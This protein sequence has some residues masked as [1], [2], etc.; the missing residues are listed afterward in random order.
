[1]HRKSIQKVV[2][3]IIFVSIVAG[4]IWG[5]DLDKGHVIHASQAG[6]DTRSGVQWLTYTNSDYGFSLDYPSNWTV[7]QGNQHAP[8]LPAETI[9]FQSPSANE[10]S[11]IV[12]HKE[13]TDDGF[14]VAQ[15]LTQAFLGDFIV[16]EISKRE[17]AGYTV[18]KAGYIQP[19]IEGISVQVLLT[20]FAT[21]STSYIVM[22]QFDVG[23]DL[24]T[25][26]SDIGLT[27]K[28]VYDQIVGSFEV[29]PQG[30]TVP[31]LDIPRE[32]EKRPVQLESSNSGLEIAPFWWP[33]DGIIG[34][35]IY[36]TGAGYTSFHKGI[37]IWT[38][39]SGTGSQASNSSKGNAIY[40]VLEGTVRGISFEPW[41]GLAW[42][43]TVAHV[44]DGNNVWTHYNHL[45]DANKL[46]SYVSPSIT[47]GLPV[48][49]QTLLGHQGNR[50]WKNYGSITVHLHLDVTTT[51]SPW[52]HYT[53][54]SPYFLAKLNA[55]TPGHLGFGHGVKH[56]PPCPK[57][58]GT[59]FVVLYKDSDYR[60]GG[61]GEDIGYVKIPVNQ[62]LP[63]TG[64]LPASFGA[65]SIRVPFGYMVKLIEK[66]N[67]VPSPIYTPGT[68][69]R[70]TSIKTFVGEWLPAIVFST[71]TRRVPLDD[72]V[73]FVKVTYVGPLCATIPIA[74]LCP[75]A[76]PFAPPLVSPNILGNNQTVFLGA[77]GASGS[78][79]APS[80]CWDYPGDLEGDEL[81]YLVEVTS[82]L[83]YS[84]SGWIRNTCWR[85][86]QLDHQYGSYHWRVKARDI[87]SA[88]SNW[89]ELGNF[90]ISSP[91][92]PPSVSFNTANSADFTT[93]GINSRTRNWTFAGTASDPEGQLN[94][95]EIRC[96]GDN[97]GNQVSHVNGN[98]WSHSRNN[99]SGQNDIYFIA[100]DNAGNYSFSRHLILRIDL[101]APT[102]QLS[103]NGEAG[104]INWHA[105]FTSPVQ[106]RLN[107]VD[108]A[109]GKAQVG[110]R[111]V[112]YRIDGGIWQTQA[113]ST[114]SFSIS[115][116]G[117]HSIEYYAIDK[118]D[119]AEAVRT[120]NFQI[121]QTPPS[122]PAGIGEM[123]G[124]VNN[125]WQKANNVPTF[126]WASSN[127]AGSG[128]WGYQF[129]FGEDPNGIAYQTFTAGQP[130]Q[131]TPQTNGVHTGVYYLRGRTRDN[132]GNWSAWANLF[133]YRY[134]GTPPENPSNVTHSA[135]IT[136][137][138]WQSTTNTANFTWPIPHDEGSG[139]KGYYAY[140]G[141]E[142]TG[143][144][145]DL[146]TLNQYQS[147]SPLC[148][149]NA[150][151]SG[152]LRL[153]SVDNVDNLANEW[154]TAF[155]L[156]YDNAPPTVD[157]NFAGD[158]TSTAQ[159][160]VMLSIMA[161][162]EGSGVRAMRFS[163]DGQTWMPWEV[164]T[165]TRVWQIPA[166]SR[167]AWPV[168]M[169]V[170]DGVDLVSPV[171]SDTIYFDVNRKQPRS[172][173]FRLFD[174]ELSAGAGAYTSTTY[175][176]RGTI[177]QVMDSPV[178]TSTHFIM[179]S[180]YEAGSRAIPLVE[181]G[182][183]EFYFVNGI[184]ASGTG[185]QTLTSTLYAL[186]GTFGE[187]GLPNTVTI[188]STNFQHQPGF[189]AAVPAMSPIVVPPGPTPIPEPDL[190]CASSSVTINEGDLY[191]NNLEVTLNLC[192]PR[193][194]EMIIGADENLTNA[195][196]EPY[197][198]TKTWLLQ[199]AGQFVAPRF[200][201]AAFKDANGTVHGTYFD[202]IIFDPTIPAGNILIGDS[203]PISPVLDSALFTSDSR[204]TPTSVRLNGVTYVQ[205]PHALGQSTTLPVLRSTVTNTVEIFVNGQDDNSGL[206]E[207]QFSDSPVFTET[208]WE[209]YS[210]LKM[211]APPESDG[212]KTVYA[213]FRDS[214]GNA[215]AVNE[216][217]FIFDTQA[218]VGGLGWGERVIGQDAITATVY[219]G[220]E[221]SWGEGGY[222]GEVADMRLSRDP[223]FVDA[224]WEP[225]TDSITLP[226]SLTASSETLYVQYRD[227]AGNVSETYS[228]T[229]VLDTTPPSIYIQ[230]EPS[231]VVTHTVKLYAYDEESD[232]TDLHISNDPLMFDAVVT[233]P[234]TD[235]FE[236]VFD[237]RQV[238][239]VQ[240]EDFVGN[241][242]E[243]TPAYAPALS[244][245][246]QVYLPL[247]LK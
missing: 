246:N 239:W 191:T 100:Y 228:D 229:L 103:L 232:V 72:N 176:G 8:T 34:Y 1:M 46:E 137:T 40:P 205:S 213:R 12:A 146:L 151:C 63:A 231:N 102:T 68:A 240:A 230:V 155:V 161:H 214:A 169:Q 115:T 164:Y 43:I 91:N 171:V 109:T 64:A 10:V 177:G 197:T 11:I 174:H 210:A 96:V 247:V 79:L 65:T 243:P 185:A 84:T 110:V 148:A 130:R 118:V 5:A 245:T 175:I 66:G 83:S 22:T 20:V 44:V 141:L 9:V 113:G 160:E 195:V 98:N 77:D 108:K 67:G 26:L 90:T 75:N 198:T 104:P 36:G 35:Y 32:I 216:A 135:G 123:N 60:C 142:A 25:P 223:S 51:A 71:L 87:R 30:P 242:S 136:S 16:S 144:T 150:A 33:T 196:W 153:R 158:V 74:E 116:D 134:D 184:F 111:E 219:L 31:T 209:P 224:A 54:P 131:W 226:I 41:S 97:C 45:A 56:E 13:A 88:E 182:H 21:H 101:A 124:V 207:M 217:T 106:V 52:D 73:G 107:S 183:D 69:L 82:D 39:K 61:D 208:V 194:N 47:I 190:A 18:T 89:S 200:V 241:L 227:L 187:F 57:S 128:V 99:M 149:T 201:Y 81:S 94:R 179:L 122:P 180:G 220:A 237:E 29:L 133:T 58:G 4:S 165:T 218:P 157:F 59:S 202:D 138:I 114:A 117:A 127:D 86:S 78:D 14:L 38:N 24:V 181:P 152:Y 199:A 19:P 238:M 167:Q 42:G 15:H 162:D 222:I 28:I 55:G 147:A 126:T 125:Q 233:M 236:W 140:W 211:W 49:P 120:V 62:P 95:V 172:A 212:V 204:V 159:T 121:D 173:N 203:M 168:F 3:S 188:T 80:L 215:S 119:N 156:R 23:V 112:R 7:G 189:L 234:V 85:P 170:Q 145:S 50:R 143:I 221:D 2:S 166:I 193:A 6:S 139:I 70:Y 192:S 53:D 186:H 225:Y 17:V 93:A 132:A 105:W 178:V 92:R 129:Y 235:T 27:R 206:A 48:T 154:S 244:A 163:T 37:D 76:P